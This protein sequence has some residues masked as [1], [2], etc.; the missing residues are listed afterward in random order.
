MSR[1][2][3]TILDVKDLRV[4]FKSLRGIV[5]VLDGVSFSLTT[6]EILG[7]VGESGCGKSVT[8][9]S[10]MGL[11]EGPQARVTSGQILFRGSDLLRRS[12][13]EL[14]QLRGKE[15]AM[16]FQDPLAS[17]NPVFTVGQQ[18]VAVIRAHRGV[19]RREA[20]DLAKSA[21]Q[22]VGLPPSVSILSS[23]PHQLSGGMR[24]RVCL[25]M[26]LSCGAP[27]L[28]GDEPTTAL[29]VTIQAQILRLLLSLRDDQGVS[30]VLITHNLGVAAQ[31]CDRIAVMYAGNIVEIGETRDVLVDPQHPYTLALK[32]CLPQG[33][34]AAELQTIRGSVPDLVDPPLGCRFH[35]RCDSA[36]GRCVDEKP[37]LIATSPDHF[38]ACHL[39]EASSATPRLE[40]V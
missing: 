26:A 32:L 37:E 8:G 24:Q 13:K 17:L 9:L 38:V 1:T 18:V 14:L 20:R 23:Y 10:V 5:K 22:S 28:I 27:L 11:L 34:L 39:L 30:M 6:G 3:E 36:F 19:S 2:D 40:V 15:L 33:K 21:L 12:E 4:E 25:G 16:V 31:T 35:P 29:D 7:L